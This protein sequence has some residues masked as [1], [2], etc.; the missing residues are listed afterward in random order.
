ML[1]EKLIQELRTLNRTDKLR[2]M[3]VLVNELAS[4]EVIDLRPNTVYELHTPYGN[5]STA[6]V[7]G[8]FLDAT[9]ENP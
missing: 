8:A 2:A 7:L 3:Q 1:S 9:K 4:E 6:Q 5:K